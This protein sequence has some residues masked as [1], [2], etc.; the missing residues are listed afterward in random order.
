M[1]TT[2]LIN[3]RVAE[4]DNWRGQ[5]FARLRHLIVEVAPDL[6]EEWKWNNPAWSKN[7]LVLGLVAETT[8][9]REWV[10]LTFFQG[11]S[12]EDS[13]GLF[14]AGLESKTMRY[15]KFREG[16]MIDELALR[17]LIRAAVAYNSAGS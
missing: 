1:N 8:K 12:L 6:R 16:D 15:I 9:V 10:Q 13:H 7:G 14:N 4:L 5:V 3:K 2:E 11:A 17:D